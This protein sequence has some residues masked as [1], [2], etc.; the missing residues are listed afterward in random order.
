MTKRRKLQRRIN[1]A[2]RLSR[3]CK[4]WDKR[5]KNRKLAAGLR[6][7]LYWLDRREAGGTHTGRTDAWPT[8]GSRCAATCIGT[9]R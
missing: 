2:E 6:L 4:R 7:Q 5:E 1:N 3:T 8:T 9:K